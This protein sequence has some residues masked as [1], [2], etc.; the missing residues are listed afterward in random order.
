MLCGNGI[1]V[2]FGKILMFHMK[3]CRIVVC[4]GMYSKFIIT[5][6]SNEEILTIVASVKVLDYGVM[7]M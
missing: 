2:T 4:R 7:S 3:R 5:T 6:F 1:V